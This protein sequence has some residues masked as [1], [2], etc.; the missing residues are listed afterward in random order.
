MS[1]GFKQLGHE[2]CFLT[3]AMQVMVL[4]PWVRDFP[5]EYKKG[6]TRLVEPH[7]QMLT[8]GDDKV[9]MNVQSG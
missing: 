4:C 6:S 9:P 3:S 1:L 2:S 7:R 8:V 5:R